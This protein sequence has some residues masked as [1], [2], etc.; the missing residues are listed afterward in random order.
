MDLNA[1]AS[2][3]SV[4]LLAAEPIGQPV[5]RDGPFVLNS[6]EELVQAVDNFREGRMGVLA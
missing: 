3:L 2:R 1:G 5:A 6:K 4:L